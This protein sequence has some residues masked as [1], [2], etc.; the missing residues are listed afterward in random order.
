MLKDIFYILFVE[1]HRK[2]VN[3]SITILIFTCYILQH[4]VAEHG[5]NKTLNID[6][7]EPVSFIG[8]IYVA[9]IRT[10]SFG[11]TF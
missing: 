9:N 3:V 5:T 6:P 7:T 11:L 1:L 8:G 10:I 2:H 4:V